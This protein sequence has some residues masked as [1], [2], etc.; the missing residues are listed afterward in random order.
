MN[1]PFP[2]HQPFARRVAEAIS[3]TGMTLRS[4]CRAAE[5][6]PSF[7]SKVLSGKRS[8]PA[9][10]QVLRRIA[11]V[12]GIDPTELIV[13]AGRIPSEWA[14]LSQDSRLF[15]RVNSLAA[16]HPV[17]EPARRSAAP[18]ELEEELL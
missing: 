3:R 2:P 6:D 7:F 4:F 13:L 17:P 5:L 16:T 11:V 12:L 1:H 15:Q 8:P 9:E 14:R 18:R 10:E